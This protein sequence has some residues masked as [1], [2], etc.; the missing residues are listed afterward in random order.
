MLL[1]LTWSPLFIW[2]NI[3]SRDNL[4]MIHSISIEEVWVAYGFPWTYAEGWNDWYSLPIQP[5]RVEFW[6][7]PALAADVLAAVA[8]VAL[9]TTVSNYLLKAVMSILTRRQ[10]P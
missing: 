1:I 3:R 4:G 8:G 5:T 2:L 7:Y 9:L 6:H 10:S